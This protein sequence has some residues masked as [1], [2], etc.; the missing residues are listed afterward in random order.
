MGILVGNAS[1]VVL[2]IAVVKTVAIVLPLMFVEAAQS[3][4]PT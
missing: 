2:T 3:P 4:N 1:V